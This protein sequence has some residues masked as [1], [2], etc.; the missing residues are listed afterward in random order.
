MSSNF[1]AVFF[2]ELAICDTIVMTFLNHSVIDSFIYWLTDGLIINDWLI[3][4]AE[5]EKKDEIE[6]RVEPP[7]PNAPGPNEKVTKSTEWI[8]RY[9]Y[10]R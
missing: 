4:F 5:E 7:N 6:R 10:A 3:I 9:I 1:V 8:F 2:C